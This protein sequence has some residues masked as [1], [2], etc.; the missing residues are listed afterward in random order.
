[1]AGGSAIGA[2]PSLSGSVEIQAGVRWSRRDSSKIPRFVG[3]S[4]ASNRPGPV[5]CALG[6]LYGF[7]QGAWPFG[8]VEVIWASVAEYRWRQRAK[9]ARGR[10][11]ERCPVDV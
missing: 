5:G 9:N 8:L 10:R 2:A 1:M 4:M 7:L 6:S 3:G 11:G